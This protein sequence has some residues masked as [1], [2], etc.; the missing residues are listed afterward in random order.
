[1]RIRRVVGLG[2]VAVQ[3]GAGRV[4]A[5]KRRGGMRAGE[6]ILEQVARLDDI[7][8]P[9]GS[10]GIDRRAVDPAGGVDVVRP[11]SRPSIFSEATPASA[12]AP[13]SATRARSFMLISLSTAATAPSAARRW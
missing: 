12:S 6:D 1:M 11:F 2:V 10:P 5:Q 8:R 9:A 3:A 4:V 13:I 7:V